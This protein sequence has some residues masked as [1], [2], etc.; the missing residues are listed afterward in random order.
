[1]AKTKMKKKNEKIR[2]TNKTGTSKYNENE[3]IKQLNEKYA[4]WKNS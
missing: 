4:T 3:N 1:M 2:N